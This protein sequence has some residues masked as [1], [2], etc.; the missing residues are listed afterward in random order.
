[1]LLILFSC[2]PVSPSGYVETNEEENMQ[3]IEKYSD[4]SMFSRPPF[5]FFFFTI[6]N[7]LCL[8]YYN[9]T[10]SFLNDSCYHLF[11]NILLFSVPSSLG[12]T[13]EI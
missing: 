11:V 1:M 10:I 13:V 8:V 5:F 2:F 12:T 7:K 4:M 6:Y 9:L 3:Q